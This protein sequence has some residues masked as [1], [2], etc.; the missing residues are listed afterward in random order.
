MSKISFKLDHVLGVSIDDS[1]IDIPKK[2]S[3]T[4]NLNLLKP[5]TVVT[6]SHNSRVMT[7]SGKSNDLSNI[8]TRRI[9]NG[10]YRKM[11][12]WH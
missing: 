8:I 3:K 12:K 9:K 11:F 7:S 4:I 5:K 1:K 2:G 6:L 10:L